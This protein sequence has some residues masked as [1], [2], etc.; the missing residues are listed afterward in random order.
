[1]D[2]NDRQFMW[3]RQVADVS[4]DWVTFKSEFEAK[5]RYEPFQQR[6][7]PNQFAKLADDGAA[8]ITF[9]TT[10][11]RLGWRE[12]CVRR[13]GTAGDWWRRRWSEQRRLRADGAHVFFA[14]PVDW[15]GAH[16]ATVRWCLK[17][18]YALKVEKR[19][20]EKQCAT[21][22]ATRPKPIGI[23]AGLQARFPHLEG[24]IGSFSASH[25]VGFF[26]A[27]YLDL[28]LR[29]ARWRFG[30]DGALF[31]VVRGETLLEAIYRQVAEAATG[32]RLAACESRDCGAIFLQTDARQQFCPPRD[33][34]TK[35]TCMNRERVRRYRTL[36]RKRQQ[37]GTRR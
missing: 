20:R 25:T 9:V 21:L 33:G 14:E 18:A 34:Q 15:I 2:T 6:E 35:S 12:L 37:K 5:S 23:G 8:L 1:M 30:Y 24:R 32:G 31:G 16:A 27:R 10:Y 7:L 36:H 22:I 28:N 17:S 4:T 29:G 11:G 19:R 26:L 3:S 13:I